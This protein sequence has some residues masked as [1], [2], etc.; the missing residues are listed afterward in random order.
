MLAEFARAI[1]AKASGEHLVH[2]AIATVQ[3]RYFDPPDLRV[4][5]GK[6]D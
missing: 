3:R 4:A 5:V 2:R 6:Y 1:G